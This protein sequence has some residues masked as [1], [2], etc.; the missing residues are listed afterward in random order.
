MISA[1]PLR[2]DYKA[3]PVLPDSLV[4]CDIPYKGTNGYEGGF[5]HSEFYE[6]TRKQ[7]ELVI[8]SEYSMPDN[9]ICIAQ[10]K[11]CVTLSSGGAKK[12]TEKLFIPGHQEELYKEMMSRPKAGELDFG[13]VA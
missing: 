10:V 13:E 7:K 8:I 11:K 12:A 4:Y 2:G 1:A 9:F 6:W 3:V 5:N